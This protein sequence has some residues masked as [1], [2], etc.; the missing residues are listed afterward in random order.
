MTDTTTP[1]GEVNENLVDAQP[2]AEVAV[3][4]ATPAEPQ[5]EQQPETE[6]TSF[7]L[8][9][10]Y[11]KDEIELDQDKA[12]EYAQKGMNYD[13]MF[14]QKQLLED[15]I[16][17]IQQASDLIDEIA[18]ETGKTRSEVIEATRRQR[19]AAKAKEQGKSVTELEAVQRADAE[20]ARADQLE[21]EQKKRERKANEW[22]EFHTT[23]PDVEPV[24]IPKDVFQSWTDG[25][26]PLLNLYKLHKY[27]QA[28]ATIQ[29]LER[30]SKEMEKQLEAQKINSE[31]TAAAPPKLGSGE[32]AEKP[33][34]KE[35]IDKMTPAELAKNHSQIWK[36][37][38]G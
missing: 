15:Q 6:P 31:N 33:L 29:E 23:Y 21:S 20:K 34:T 28:Q 27:D 1:V 35:D 22:S 7:K 24:S 19:L 18:K 26:T 2:Q 16:K 32:P 14:E 4:E 10:K 36:I 8:K 9:V 30:K 38:T 13:K 3:S 5:A 17:E 37:L 11:N 25:D 12:V